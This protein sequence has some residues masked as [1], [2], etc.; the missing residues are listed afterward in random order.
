MK[1]LTKCKVENASEIEGHCKLAVIQFN[2]EMR[3]GDNVVAAAHLAKEEQ[4][5]EGTDH[6]RHAGDDAEQEERRRLVLEVGLRAL[7]AALGR[8]RYLDR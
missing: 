2:I 5:D 1:R 7:V 6:V 3:S 4:R 8:T